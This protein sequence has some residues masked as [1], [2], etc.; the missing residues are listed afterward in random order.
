MCEG[1]AG[2]QTRAMTAT[3]AR[4]GPSRLQDAALALLALPLLGAVLPYLVFY[5]VVAFGNGPG[6]GDDGDGSGWAFVGYGM[7]AGPVVALVLDIVIAV[8]SH[9]AGY[10]YLPVAASVSPF[11]IPAVLSSGI[12]R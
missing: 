5:A 11:V 8:R 12:L 7:I 3:P 6:S 2:S 9:R 4:I 10:Q 1:R